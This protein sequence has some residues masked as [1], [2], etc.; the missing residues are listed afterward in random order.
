M[1][2]TCANCDHK[3]ICSTASMGSLELEDKSCEHW[4]GWHDTKEELPDDGRIIL[5]IAETHDG[6]QHIGGG[7]IRIKDSVASL[8]FFD[9]TVLV[10]N[11][12]VRFWRYLPNMR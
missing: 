1:R 3:L 7:T 11:D 8:Y 6:N 12:I 10:K 9:K 5:V 2:K 4:S